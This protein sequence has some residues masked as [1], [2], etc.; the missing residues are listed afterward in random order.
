MR[1]VATRTGPAM[2]RRKT[3]SFP[4]RKVLETVIV[5]KRPMEKL[6]CGHLQAPRVNKFN[7]PTPATRRRCDACDKVVRRDERRGQTSLMDALMRPDE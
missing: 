3:S 7:H 6:E 5:N 2:A 1:I 4:L